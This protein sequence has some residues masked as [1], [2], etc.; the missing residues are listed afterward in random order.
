VQAVAA[1]EPIEF[2]GVNTDEELEVA[3]KVIT[4]RM[5]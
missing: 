1:S 3:E 2:L 4:Q 5:R